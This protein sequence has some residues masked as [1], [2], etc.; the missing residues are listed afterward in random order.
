[1]P[2]DRL[3]RPFSAGDGKE[4]APSPVDWCFKRVALI[5]AGQMAEA[6]LEAIAAKVK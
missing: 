1:V 4:P 5:G 2:Y 3:S 6:I